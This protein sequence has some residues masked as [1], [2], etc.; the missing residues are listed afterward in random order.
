M[1]QNSTLIHSFFLLLLMFCVRLLSVLM[2][3]LS[4]HHLTCCNMLKFDLKNQNV[5]NI[6]LFWSDK[7]IKIWPGRF[8]GIAGNAGNHGNDGK[9]HESH[10]IL[11]QIY[12]NVNKLCLG[13]ISRQKEVRIKFSV[14][15]TFSNMFYGKKQKPWNAGNQQKA[16]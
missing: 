4:I 15:S 3:L 9:F 14:D 5:W 2:I 13:K 6:F 1:S 10:K 12:R 16:F 8:P 7:N 11:N